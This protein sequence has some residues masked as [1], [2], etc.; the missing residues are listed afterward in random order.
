M[1]LISGIG[2]GTL[3]KNQS[4]IRDKKYT[5]IEEPYWGPSTHVCP[6]FPN[7]FLL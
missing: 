5:W 2:F 1:S 7:T 4:G 6:N 3:K